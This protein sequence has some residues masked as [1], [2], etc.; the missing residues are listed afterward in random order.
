MVLGLVRGYDTPGDDALK[1]RHYALVREFTERFREKSGSIN[2]RE[3]LTNAGVLAQ[4]GGDPEA[5]TP[6]YYEKRPCPKLV[7]EAAHILDEM[8]AEREKS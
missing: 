8:L 2:C 4:I 6:D 3:L 1:K 7:W 5:R